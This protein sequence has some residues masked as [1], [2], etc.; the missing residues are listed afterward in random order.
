M[1]NITTIIMAII[2]GILILASIVQA[3]QLTSLKSNAEKALFKTT[4]FPTNTKTSSTGATANLPAQLP[5]QVG[6]C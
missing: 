3:V 5:Q 1:K 4:G 6:G 2:L